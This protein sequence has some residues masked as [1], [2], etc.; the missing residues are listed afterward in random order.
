MTMAR[1][2]LIGFFR[3]LGARP[4]KSYPDLARP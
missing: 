4:L 2:L 1:V 3:I